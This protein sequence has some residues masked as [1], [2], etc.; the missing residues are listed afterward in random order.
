MIG[1]WGAMVYEAVKN[2]HLSLDSRLNLFLDYGIAISP[3]K[4]PQKLGSRFVTV[5]NMSLRMYV[6]ALNDF[7]GC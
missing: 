5:T 6:I 1:M 2:N 7:H 3:S 4:A